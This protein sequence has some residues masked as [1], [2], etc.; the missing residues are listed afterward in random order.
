M[1]P[2]V[3]GI[4]TALGWGSADFIARFTGRALGHE[5]AL[6]GMLSVS[7][8]ALSVILWWADVPV[9]LQLDGLWLLGLTGIG[10]MVATLLLYWG[11]AR[12]PVTIVAPIVGSY[13]A[14]NVALAVLLG[15]RPS[16]AQWIAIAVVMTGVTVVAR[17][18]RSFE[19]D[20]DYS[21]AALRKTLGIAL[22]SALV[23]A[24]T[25]A[26][27]QAAAPIYGELPTT[28]MA[29]WISWLA[30]VVLFV[31]VR[32]STPRIPGP[33]WPVLAVQG[34]LDGGAYV[35]LFA[36]GLQAKAEI[37]AVVASAF[38]AVTVILARV[39][40]REAMT[41]PQWLG[42]ALIV[43]GAAILSWPG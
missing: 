27:G 6:F 8:V 39:F 26:A 7:A 24:A 28:V 32:R 14:V 15:S 42:I 41:A 20:G 43:G 10:V 22:A 17:A 5:A 9:V 16:L 38:S 3:L 4:L 11:L 40:L 25:V 18:A 31:A 21:V 2:A 36:S 12:G 34:L 33:W 19:G 37:A 35:T 1:N 23:F 29:R 13:P 30:I